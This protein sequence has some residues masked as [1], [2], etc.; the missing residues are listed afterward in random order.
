LSAAAQ[1][2]A[3]STIMEP[4]EPSAF[5]LLERALPT[6]STASWFAMIEHFLKSL[7]TRR[8]CSWMVVFLVSASA[9]AQEPLPGTAEG[10]IPP[11][12]PKYLGREIAQ[13]MHFEGAPW[14]MRETRQREEDCETLLQALNVQPGQV[15]CDMGCGNGFYTLQLAKLVGEQGKVLAVDIQPEML[16]M[17]SERARESG[18]TN[19]VPV[20]GTQ[21]DPRLEPASVDLILL[22]DVYHEFSHPAQMLVAMRTALKPG[23]RIALAEFRLEDRSVPIK[24]LHKMS[25]K[26]ILREYSA[27][28]LKLVE[29]FDKLPWQHLMFFE[30]D[31]QP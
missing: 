25:K 12:K 19:I 20:A 15:V 14:L 16:H 27:N 11:A 22:V 10:E 23:G 9:S 7:V 30:R 2:E 5:A 8:L 21:I 26:Q 3:D 17:L 28:E 24:R 29:E 18:I 1:F 6:L 31:E 13:T 4:A